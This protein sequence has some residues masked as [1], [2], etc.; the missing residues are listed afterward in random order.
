VPR[1]LIANLACFLIE[2]KPLQRQKRPDHV[3]ADSLCFSLGLS[4][5]LAVD[6]E[7]CMAPAENFPLSPFLSS[8]GMTRRTEP[9]CL[10]GKHQQALFPTVGTPDAGKAAHR[11]A[12]VQ[13]LPYNILDHRPEIPVLL[14]EPIPIFSKELRKVIKEYPIKNRVFWMTLAVDSCHGS[15][16]DS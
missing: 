7:T 14:F 12:A 15:G 10:S 1:I 8:L 5:D 2:E 13:I 6:I 9:A 11:I 16:Y 4:L 3:F